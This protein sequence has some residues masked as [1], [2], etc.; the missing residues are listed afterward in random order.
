MKIP[1]SHFDIEVNYLTRGHLTYM[2]GGS[3]YTLDPGQFTAFWAGLPH[4]I[5]EQSKGTRMIWITIPF[6]TAMQWNLPGKFIRNLLLGRMAHYDKPFVKASVPEHLQLRQWIHELEEVPS[7][8]PIIVSEIELRLQRLALNWSHPTVSLSEGSHTRLET[9]KRIFGYATAHYAEI[10]SVQDIAAS[11]H[12]HPK[13]LMQCFRK[14]FGI[15]LWDYIIRMRIAKAQKLLLT[16]NQ[17]ITSIAFE[18]GY[19]TLSAFYAAFRQH[20][21]NL[22]PSRFRQMNS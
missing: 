10:T 20:T 18:C 9:A 6:L 17:P 1:H 15:R 11:L 22:S 5:N 7:M 19:N 14:Y 8:H 13:Y 2:H 3:W 21:D 12:L 4:I 16:T